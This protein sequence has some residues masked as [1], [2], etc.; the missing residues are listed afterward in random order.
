MQD[1]FLIN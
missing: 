1:M